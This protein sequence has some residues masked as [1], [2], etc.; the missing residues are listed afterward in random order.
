MKI[1]GGYSNNCEPDF[2][3]ENCCSQPLHIRA[4]IVAVCT[5]DHHC[6]AAVTSVASRRGM[7]KEG[8]RGIQLVV[9]QP[10]FPISLLQCCALLALHNILNVI[11]YP[12]SA[13]ISPVII[14][15]LKHIW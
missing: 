15:H 11:L 2:A 7:D 9:R 14:N 3:F 13:S 8:G 10:R 4:L 12:G 5:R 6:S 1:H